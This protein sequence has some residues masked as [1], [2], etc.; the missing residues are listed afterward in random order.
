M[1]AIGLDDLK[2]GKTQERIQAS[3]VREQLKPWDTFAP[4]E[5]KPELSFAQMA[6]LNAR[7]IVRRNKEMAFNLKKSLQ[8]DDVNLTF[9]DDVVD[10]P[11]IDL[12]LA[13]LNAEGRRSRQGW[14][15]SFRNTL[16]L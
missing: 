2:K 14:L 3:E 6:V 1:M 10:D 11:S 9:L 15:Q 4:Q 16:G 12:E 5:E 13:A 8:S 7:E